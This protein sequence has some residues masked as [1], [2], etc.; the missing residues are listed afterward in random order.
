MTSGVSHCFCI[1][2]KSSKALSGIIPFLHPLISALYATKLGISYRVRI[3]SKS[4]NAASGLMPFSHVPT[5][6]L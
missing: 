2:S 1:A 4:S 5:D 6:A 3:D